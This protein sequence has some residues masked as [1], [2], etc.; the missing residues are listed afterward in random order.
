MSNADDDA[1]SLTSALSKAKF[2]LENHAF[3]QRITNAI[4]ISKFR[5]VPASERYIAATRSDGRGELR[6]YSGYTIRFLD[7]GSPPRGGGCGHY[8]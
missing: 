2:P 4:G 6:I 5:F 8:P 7:E 1:D 3:I